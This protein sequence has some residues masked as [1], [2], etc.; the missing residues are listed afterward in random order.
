MFEEKV[1][2]I[3]TL[4]SAFLLD[5]ES[6]LTG[7]KRAT[8]AFRNEEG[9]RERRFTYNAVDVAGS[10]MSLPL[11]IHQFADH[12]QLIVSKMKDLRRGYCQ[13]HYC[14]TTSVIHV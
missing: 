6:T 1:A 12:C 7:L 9:L 13:C 2:N 5:G 4:L 14:S 8:V 3:S 10:A 11:Q